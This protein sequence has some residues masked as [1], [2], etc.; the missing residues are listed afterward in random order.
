MPDLQTNEPP[1]SLCL[2]RLSALG[3]VCNT[4][5]LVRALQRAWPGTALSW[6]VGK[7]EHR[8]VHDL[9]GVEFIVFDKKGPFAGFRQA[10]R[11]LSPRHFDALLLTQVSQRSSLLASLVSADRRIG[12]DRARSRPGHGLVINE[13]INAVPFQHQVDAF[14]EFARYLGLPTDGVDRHLPVPEQARE[15]ARHHQPDADRAVII[16]PASSH[17]PRNW[18]P[19]GYAAVADW[20]IETTGRTVILMGGPGEME[21]A[22]GAAVERE[23]K[24]KP[25]NLIGRDTI[26]QALAMFE[27]AACVISPD[28]GPAHFA[29]AMGTP[30]VGLYAATWARR[31]GPIDSLAHTVDCFPQAA[32]EFAGRAPEKL[33]WGKRLERPGVMELITPEMVV[34]KLE[35]L[36][37]S[38]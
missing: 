28:S 12:F 6:I 34:E 21:K 3:D 27:R 19:A 26:K 18:H 15:F 31:S 7:A 36:L 13:R 20:V 38:R 14:L 35:Q 23:M 33:R 1:S 37:G 29:D 11:S 10:R 16:S 9:P 5:P 25:L 24:H 4:V 8:L 32:R 2:L 22:L 30:V 17:T